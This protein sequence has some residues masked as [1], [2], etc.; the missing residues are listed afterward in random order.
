MGASERQNKHALLQWIAI[1]FLLVLS[2]VLYTYSNYVRTEE[3]AEHEHIAT[4]SKSLLSAQ[5]RAS[6]T[7]E[8]TVGSTASQEVRMRDQE[9]QRMRDQEMQRNVYQW[10]SQGED[11][12]G[13][14]VGEFMSS[15]KTECAAQ[16]S[17]TPA[18]VGFTLSLKLNRCWLKAKMDVGVPRVDRINYVISQRS[19]FIQSASEIFEILAQIQ[20]PNPSARSQEQ[21]SQG[22][23]ILERK[24]PDSFL[25]TSESQK[26]VTRLCTQDDYLARATC[27]V[28]SIPNTSTNGGSNKFLFL[29]MGNKAFLPFIHNWLCNTAHMHGVHEREKI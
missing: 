24:F 25:R 15:N 26:N 9:A 8:P 12:E 10:I 7:S 6:M 17:A 22:A 19:N 27:L 29:I 28:A 18:C 4:K 3:H 16:C 1:L 11:F 23:S 13:N 20:T 21:I 5:V 2:N 14:D